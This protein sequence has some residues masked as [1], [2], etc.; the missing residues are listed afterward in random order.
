[1][2]VLVTGANGFL[3]ANIIRELNRRLI[4]ARA[5]VRE[6]ADMK[7]LSG[8][9]FETYY[10][11]I[12]E[13]KQVVEASF[14]CDYVVH[15]AANTGPA[16]TGYD[17][18]HPVNVLGTRNVIEAVKINGIKRLV[19]ISTANT[20]GYGDKE[21]PG[22]EDNPISPLFSKSGYALSKLEAE[23]IIKK[24]VDEGH[25]DAIILNPTFMIGPADAKPSSGMVLL[26]IV[27]RPVAFLPPGGKNFIHVRNVASA[28]CEAFTKGRSGERYLLANDNI[29]FS[30][31]FEMVNNIS[32]KKQSLIVLPKWLLLAIGSMCSLL[33]FLGI[34]TKLTY[35]NSKLI[36]IDNYYS[37]Q[38]AVETFGLKFKPIKKAVDE[39]LDWYVKNEYLKPPYPAYSV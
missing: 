9:S 32:G 28:C 19:F 5:F 27:D 8:Y 6:S 20:I 29:S 26:N 16:P 33:L 25:L 17:F 22:F 21:S 38:K 13:R 15:A 7:S 37:G 4:P 12:T 24:E 1:M 3:G 31:F 34:R 30:D 36:C 39:A 14:G 2:K 23:R 10:G 18:Y 11:D 35:L